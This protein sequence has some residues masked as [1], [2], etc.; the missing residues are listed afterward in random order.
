MPSERRGRHRPTT[1]PASI[2]S[3]LRRRFRSSCRVSSTE[4]A[5]VAISHGGQTTR[6]V[7]LPR[8]RSLQPLSLSVSET[9]DQMVVHHADRLHRSPPFLRDELSLSLR[10]AM[11]KSTPPR[12]LAV[13]YG[14]LG[15]LAGSSRRTPSLR[16]SVEKRRTPCH[17]PVAIFSAIWD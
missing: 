7:R 15:A 2:R 12:R 9:A 10:R 4:C 6:S 14:C 3:F 16:S 17:C 11:K 8:F 13:Y 5:S 1:S